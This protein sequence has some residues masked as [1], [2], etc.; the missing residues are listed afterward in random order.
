MKSS[1]QATGVPMRKSGKGTCFKFPHSSVS[2]IR[3]VFKRHCGSGSG[4][5]LRF[6]L[7]YPPVQHAI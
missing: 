3:N 2:K 7:P 6:R 4:S 1:N 5:G